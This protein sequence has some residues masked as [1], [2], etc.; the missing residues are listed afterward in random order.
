M[1]KAIFVGLA[2]VW[3]SGSA[4]ADKGDGKQPDQKAMMEKWKAVMTP[5]EPHKRMAKAVGKWNS[6]ARMW[7]QGPGSPP[8]ESK[9]T[10]ELSLLLGGRFLRRDVSSTMMG[11]PFQGIGIDGYDNFTKQYHSY[12]IDSMGTTSMNL[13]GTSTDGG[14]T[15]TYTGA[16]DEPM[17]G[18]RN[19]HVKAIVRHIDD[20]KTVFEMYDSAGGKEWKAFEVTYTRAK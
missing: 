2:V 9:G 10:A 3:F 6:V 15:V 5:G 20:D 16:M 14:K 8:M 19:K 13:K 17:T 11:M 18:E 7:M 12:W 4:L 1:R